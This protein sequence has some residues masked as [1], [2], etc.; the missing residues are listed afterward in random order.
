MRY[1][2]IVLMFLI[3]SCSGITDDKRE[4]SINSSLYN[5]QTAMRWGQWDVVFGLRSKDAP[6]IPDL[7]FEDTQVTAYD[8]LQ[9]PVFIAQDHMVQVAQIQYIRSDEQRVRK[10]MDKQD[11]RYDAD[12]SVWLLHSPFPDFR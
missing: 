11:W 10:V 2:I 9:P 7:P 5:Y 1:V 12:N 3:V 6:P 4:T 8:I